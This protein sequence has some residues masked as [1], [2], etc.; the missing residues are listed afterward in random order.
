MKIAVVGAGLSGLTFAAAAQRFAPGAEVSL[1]ERDESATSRTQGYAIGL[2]LGFGLEALGTLG[3]RER[4]IG[5]VSF[6]VTDF[7]ILD[8][9]GKLLLS[10]RSGANG[11]NVTYR[12]QGLHLKDVM[13][14]AVGNIPINYARHCVGV[15]QSSASA[16]AVFETARAPRLITWSD[17]TERD[18]RSG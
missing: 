8:Q 11:P 6:K 12:V 7:A 15:E 3:L 4:V 5:D 10:L 16:T 9:K 2:R 18:R 14:D 1:Y 13:R 17:A